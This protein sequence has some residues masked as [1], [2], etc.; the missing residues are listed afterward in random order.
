MVNNSNQT[1]NSCTKI[2]QL[3]PHYLRWPPLCPNPLEDHN[4]IIKPAPLYELQAVKDLVKQHRVLLL[5]DRAEENMVGEGYLAL[6]PPDWNTDEICHVIYALEKSDYINSQWC[7]TAVNRNIP[8]D[9]YM[10]SYGRARRARWEHGWK[11][12]IKFGYLPM[13]NLTAAV[14]SFHMSKFQ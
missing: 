14:C 4:R 3:P 5:T 7:R 8:C 1:G 12:Y 2:A 6:P 9:S 11:L 13:P 10:V